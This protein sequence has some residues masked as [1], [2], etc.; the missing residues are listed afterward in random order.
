MKDKLA[1]EKELLGLYVSGHPLEKYRETIV[2]KDMDIKKARENKKDGDS[3]VLAIIINAVRMV[4][5]K[6]K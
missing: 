4:Q 2:K 5:T 1:W 3:V 6:N